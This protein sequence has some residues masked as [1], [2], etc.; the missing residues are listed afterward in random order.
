MTDPI[1]SAVVGSLW[2]V[3]K[4][5]AACVAATLLA[6]LLAGCG[7]KIHI[8]NPKPV[9]VNTPIYTQCLA[10]ADADQIKAERPAKV[11]GKL[12][13][14]AIR[15]VLLL[16]AKATRDEVWADKVMAVLDGC[17]K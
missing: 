2:D 7:Q 6:C 15:D 1:K 14:D 12:T 11:G 13:G 3:A 4:F 16:G 5:I 9:Y 8:D 10:R 17:T